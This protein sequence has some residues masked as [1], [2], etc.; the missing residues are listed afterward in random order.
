MKNIDMVNYLRDITWWL[1]GYIAGSRDN[2]EYCPFD[3]DHLD[4]LEQIVSAVLKG[5]WTTEEKLE[6]EVEE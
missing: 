2:M 4:A 6:E 1:R 3:E 5:F